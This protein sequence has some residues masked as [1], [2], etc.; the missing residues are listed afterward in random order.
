RRRW[1]AGGRGDGGT[2]DKQL[3][4][5]PEGVGR[6]DNVGGA[7]DPL[8]IGEVEAHRVGGGAVDTQA[9]RVGGGGVGA[10]AGGDGVFEPD[11]AGDVR[12][13]QLPGV[14]AVG[15]GG[16]VDLL[17][18]GGDVGAQVQGE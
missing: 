2:V 3:D 5:L 8:V 6:A 4:V 12:G 7:V 16:E 9:D 18:L 1:E 11:L 10:V 15:V 14:G 13:R 17:R